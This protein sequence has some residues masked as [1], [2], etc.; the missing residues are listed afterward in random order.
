MH[1][2][3]D[4]SSLTNHWLRQL[5]HT[6]CTVKTQLLLV[7]QRRVV[8]GRKLSGRVVSFAFQ[9]VHPTGLIHLSTVIYNL[10]IFLFYRFKV[11]TLRSEQIY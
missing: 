8:S 11:L 4:G 5:T 9:S 10:R 2:S 7:S 1:Q 3:V 6:A